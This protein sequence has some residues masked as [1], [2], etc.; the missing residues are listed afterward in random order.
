MVLFNHEEYFVDCPCINALFS[1]QMTCS[2]DIYSIWNFTVIFYP[3]ISIMIVGKQW[4]V[5]DLRGDEKMKIIAKVIILMV[6]TAFTGWQYV[7]T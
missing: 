3:V 5:N 2:V 1:L 6:G 7:S 4:N